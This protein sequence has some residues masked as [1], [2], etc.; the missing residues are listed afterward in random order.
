[1]LIAYEQFAPP[2]KYF[3]LTKHEW[4]E[5]GNVLPPKWIQ[6]SDSKTD[7]NL[8]ISRL[9]YIPSHKESLLMLY[10]FHIWWGFWCAL[11]HKT[12][13]AISRI[14]EHFVFW[15][16]LITNFALWG[17]AR[18]ERVV[19]LSRIECKWKTLCFLSL[20]FISIRFGSCEV[21]R[22]TPT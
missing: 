8:D 15:I 20:S 14:W 21:R 1:M 3:V 4:P 12:L 19:H 13:N 18:V 2:E 7:L 11:L 22:L 10:S 9:I 17:K 6:T 16:T 5:F